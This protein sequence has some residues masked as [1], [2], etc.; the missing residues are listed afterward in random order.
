MLNSRQCI[1]AETPATSPRE[2]AAGAPGQGVADDYSPLAS[3][4]IV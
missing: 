1:L 3:L 2:V 4:Q